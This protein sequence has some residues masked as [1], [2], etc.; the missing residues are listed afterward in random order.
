M[1]NADIIAQKLAATGASHAF[2]IP[3]G[4]VLTL[5]DAL[6]RAG[7][8]FT[9]TKHE[10][11][12]GF[13]AEGTWH[14]TGAP[15][16]LVATIGPGV[17]NAV[18]VI[19]NAF[20]DRVPLIVLT[21]CVD[22][23]DADTYTHQVFDHGALLSS[24]VKGTFK[25]NGKS[26]NQVMDKALT[27]ATT[28][29]PGPVHID[30]PIAVADAPAETEATAP[31][32]IGAGFRPVEGPE[33][34]RARRWIAEAERP[35][36]IAGVD[37]VNDDAGEALQTFCRRIGAS[38]ITTYKAK[39]LLDESDRLSLGAAGLSPL[40][41]RHLMPLVEASDCIVLAGY[42]PIEMRLGW[43]NPWPDDAK[44]IDVTPVV[45]TH[46]MH[47]VAITL[48]GGIA[49]ALNDL[50][51]GVHTPPTWAGGEPQ[52]VQVDLRH[53]FAAEPEGWGPA[54]VFHTLRDA[55][56]KAAVVTAD[57]G[58][59]RILLSQIWRCA[60]PRTMLQ[61]SALCTMGCSV[62]LAA[63]YKYAKPETPVVAFVGDAGLE[64]GLGDL[65][66]VRDLGIA[67][68]IVVLVD[69]SLALIELKQRGQQLAN[70][71][72]DFAKTDFPAVATALGGYGVWIDDAETLRTAMAEALERPTFTLLCARI[73][74]RA[75]DGKF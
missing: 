44:V 62:P 17:A 63:G 22:D 49:V 39:G 45:R 24:I 21:G 47:Q 26:L 51:D 65:A 60:T 64:M 13:M 71:G 29:Q 37:A 10:N 66:T 50:V 1:R 69:E 67:L 34:R 19:A 46:G 2:G 4:E 43:R 30:L 3:G 40:A 56:P 59:H 61:S 23:A 15:G 18:N 41:D 36:V 5:I 58:A 70:L 52:K 54:T 35:L 14:A 72:V 28:G 55:L 32:V 68:P 27:L 48:F 53:A 74:R 16:I 12:A 33:M 20:Q 38:L 8:H 75:Y 73:G 9:L 57:S 31:I 7:I 6:E 11:V 42:D 25:A